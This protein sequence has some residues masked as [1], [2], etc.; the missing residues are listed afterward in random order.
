M[1]IL[2]VWLEVNGTAAWPIFSVWDTIPN[3]N[4]LLH[5]E[6]QQ[7][8]VKIWS[9]QMKME[10]WGG[11]NHS[12]S[13][14]PSEQSVTFLNFY[15]DPQSQCFILSARRGHLMVRCHYKA[16]DL[17]SSSSK[18]GEHCLFCLCQ[19][20]TRAPRGTVVA[21]LSMAACNHIW[22]S[23]GILKWMGWKLEKAP[24]TKAIYTLAVGAYVYPFSHP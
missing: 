21:M 18:C 8:D 1:F 5:L 6:S 20:W 17:V 15:P 14:Q 2:V 13:T 22:W 11:Q 16:H 12:V 4:Q 24:N 23:F 3:F 7:K 19:L 9:R 10:L